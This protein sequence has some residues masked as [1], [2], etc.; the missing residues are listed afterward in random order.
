MDWVDIVILA[1]IFIGAISGLRRGLVMVLFSLA[2]YVVGVFLAIRYQTPLTAVLLAQ[3][4]VSNWIHH[5]LPVPAATVPGASLEAHRMIHSLV[6]LLVFLVVIGAAELAGRLVGS[7]VTRMVKVFRVTGA[8]N[9]IGGSLAGVAEHGVMVG[10]VLTMVLAYPALSHSPIT[11][12]IH[13]APLASL[14][15]GWMGHLAKI[16]GGTFL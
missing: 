6:A 1:Y 12:L 8:L 3:L 2:G 10:L 15:A 9:S 7:T 4:P 16:P 5:L 11:T 13:R 14:L